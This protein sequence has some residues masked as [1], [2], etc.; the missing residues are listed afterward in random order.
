[1][2]REAA[3]FVVVQPV[4]ATARRM[5]ETIMLCERRIIASNHDQGSKYSRSK[6]SV[7]VSALRQSML[8]VCH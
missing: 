5:M 1:M 3:P 6:C 4:S 2:P 8:C 7:P